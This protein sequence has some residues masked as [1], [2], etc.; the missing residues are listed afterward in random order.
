MIPG[1]GVMACAGGREILAGNRELLEEHDIT[2]EDKTAEDIKSCLLRGNTAVYVAID[3]RF[4]GY[5]A[6]ADTLRPESVDTISRITALDIHPVLITGDREET[7]KSIA[8]V[9]QIAEVHGNCRPEDK[10]NWISHYEENCQLICMIGDGVN[11]APAL[12]KAAVGIAM[13]GVG[14]DIAVDASD[15]VLVSDEIKELPH[16][17]ELSRKMMNTIKCNLSFSM[18]LNFLALALAMAGILNPVVGALVHNAGSV[19]VIIHSAVLLKWS[20]KNRL[21]VSNCSEHP[22]KQ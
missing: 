22:E 2:I 7:A 1:R 18:I 21:A 9:L 12:K 20:G 15:I 19:L 14:S 8:G 6:L 13:G 16:L 17:L 5:L 11:D 10:L 3:G 4:A